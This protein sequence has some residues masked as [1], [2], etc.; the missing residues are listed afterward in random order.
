MRPRLVGGIG[1]LVALVLAACS[2]GDDD[3]GAPFPSLT[4]FPSPLADQ[5]HAIRDRAARLRGLAPF[6]GVV[7]GTITRE[8]LAAYYDAAFEELDEEERADIDASE[9]VLRL[10]GLIDVDDDLRSIFTEEFSGV[11]AGQYVP[12]EDRLVLV[13]AADGEIGISDEI[14]LAHEYVHSFQD[15]AYDLDAF[16]ERWAKS[17]LERDGYTQYSETLNCLIE[18]DASLADELYAEE[19]FGPDWRE[20]AAAEAPPDDAANEIDIPPFLLRSFAFRYNECPAFVRSLYDEGGWAAVNAAFEN[21]PDTTEQVLHPDKYR[22]RELANTGPPVDLTEDL[23]GWKQLD[24]A[25]FGEY[26]VFNYAVTLTGSPEAAV[27]AAAGWGSGWVRS[28]RDNDD[29]ARAVV[30]L[31]LGWDTRQDLVEF[32][33]V[34]DAILTARGAQV[35]VVSEGNIRWTAEGQLGVAFLDLMLNRVEF[36]FA[37][38]ADALELATVD[39]EAFN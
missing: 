14:T 22:S 39:L 17:D 18:G 15:G 1:P 26:D 6:D 3:G 23:D 35:E 29:S 21:P 7:E 8:T 34:F 10:L 4:P 20:Q 27:V 36:R 2:G 16:R 12:E 33:S 30:Q 38:D 9:V 13:T 19:V 28:Y 37:T 24:S 25:Q 31:S 32:V 5:L 11:I